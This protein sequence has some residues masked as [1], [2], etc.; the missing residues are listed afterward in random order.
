MDGIKVH[1]NSDKPVQQF[2]A[3]VQRVTESDK[4]ND[5]KLMEV[6]TNLREVITPGDVKTDP[7]AA[8]E[9]DLYIKDLETVMKNG[10]QETKRL[11]LEGLYKEANSQLGASPTDISSKIP[12][13]G[14]ATIQLKEE[15]VQRDL[16]IGAIVGIT[17]VTAAGAG[18][19]GYGIYKLVKHICANRARQYGHVPDMEQDE[20]ELVDIIVPQQRRNTILL[21][22]G[23]T[24]IGQAGDQV[25]NAG[26]TS[27]GLVLG[28]GSDGIALYHWPGMANGYLNN[29]QGIVNQ[30]G[31][32]NR[33]EIITNNFPS[34]DDGT[35]RKDYTDTAKLIKSTYGVPIAYYVH[36]E[37]DNDVDPFGKLEAN[38]FNSFHP[39]TEIDLN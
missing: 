34:R 38:H 26:T 37:Q 2:S 18:L 25:Q 1:S 11:T 19:L 30:V 31:T 22:Q 29:F 33:I 23:M 3:V 21:T 15:V 24:Q 36:T 10:D 9:M 27:C 28:F 17:L 35:L 8:R 16:G 12:K 5:A 20:E 39:T 7:K 13:P 4:E 14:D 32:L 6:I